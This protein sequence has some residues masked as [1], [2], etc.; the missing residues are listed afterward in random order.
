MFLATLYSLSVFGITLLQLN[1]AI[2]LTSIDRLTHQISG[3]KIVDGY[4]GADD[5]GAGRRGTGTAY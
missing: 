3:G 5:L 1:C 4:M 2:V